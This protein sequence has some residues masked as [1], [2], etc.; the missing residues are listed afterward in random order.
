MEGFARRPFGSPQ[1]I[2]CGHELDQ[3]M[4]TA[5]GDGPCQMQKI[6]RRRT[7]VGRASGNESSM[8]ALN[9]GKRVEM[10]SR[11]RKRPH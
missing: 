7:G 4:G 8:S 11:Q 2:P 3:A 6:V 10:Y 9:A 1:S 5:V